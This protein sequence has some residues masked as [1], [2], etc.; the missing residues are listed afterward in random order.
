MGST[1]NSAALGGS[2]VGGAGTKQM[3]SEAWLLSFRQDMQKALDTPH[4][5]RPLTLNECRDQVLQIFDLKTTA[6][7]KALKSSMVPIDTMELFTYKTM[8]K[9]YGLRSL[10]VEHAGALLTAVQ[11]YTTQDFDI[12]LYS[13]MFH[14]EVEEEFRDVLEELKRSVVDLLRVQL[15]AR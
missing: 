9:R 12:M 14:N 8:E 13:K 11:R 5:C 7:A 10:A 2:L 4:R 6:N 15:M 1:A 3:N